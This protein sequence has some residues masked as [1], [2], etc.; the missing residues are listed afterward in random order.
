MFEGK[1]MAERLREKDGNTEKW[2]EIIHTLS[3]L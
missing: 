2:E 3:Y 1:K